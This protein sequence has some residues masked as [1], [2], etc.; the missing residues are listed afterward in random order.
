MNLEA[1]RI[2][3]S[4]EP[5]LSRMNQNSLPLSTKNETQQTKHNLTPTNHLSLETTNPQLPLT[6]HLTP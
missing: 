3:Y 1:K 4:E 2:C 6:L 5:L